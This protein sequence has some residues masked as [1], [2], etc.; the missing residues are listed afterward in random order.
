MWLLITMIAIG[1]VLALPRDVASRRRD[2]RETMAR[3]VAPP[4]VTAP[5]GPEQ[6][7]QKRPDPSERDQAFR[8][9]IDR[10]VTRARVSGQWRAAHAYARGKYRGAALRLMSRALAQ[11]EVAEIDA[12]SAPKAAPARTP[13]RTR[14][15]YEAGR[16]GAA[17]RVS[18]PARRRHDAPTCAKYRDEAGEGEI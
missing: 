9:E 10:V 17:P 13:S 11:A 14:Q 12:R 1:I 18:R 16:Q 5:A 2:R 8:E 15:A 3:C 7:F 4:L 6:R